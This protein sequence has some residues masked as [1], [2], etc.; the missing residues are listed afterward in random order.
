MSDEEFVKHARFEYSLAKSEVA[1]LDPQEALIRFY[2]R[3]D[4][5]IKT[6]AESSEVKPACRA[7][8][9]YCCYYK[10]EAKAVEVF[11]IQRFVSARFTQQQ[12]ELV[13]SQARANV[14]QA[15]SLS[16]EE[17]LA[18]NQRC[19]FLIEDQCSIYPVRPSKCRNFHASEVEGCKKSYEEPYNL[20][21]P[22]SFIEPILVAANGA[23]EGFEH[24]VAETGKDAR[25]YDLNSAFLEAMEN[26]ASTKRFGGGKK[27]FIS[28]KVV[29]EPGAGAP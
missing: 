13:V 20:A 24:A 23:T 4:R 17:H 5:A 16:Y 12:R 7:G 6:S 21:L 8:C 11:A 9:S 19:P 18:T 1:K 15:K 22:N 14:E 25:T 27:A 3:L 2:G 26:P 29:S 10:V 28:A